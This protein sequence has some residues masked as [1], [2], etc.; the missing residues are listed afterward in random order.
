MSSI[1]SMKAFPFATFNPNKLGFKKSKELE[2]IIPNKLGGYSS[3]TVIGLNSNGFHGLLVSGCKGLRR[4]VYLQKL[5]DEIEFKNSVLGL[6]TNEYSDGTTSD[7]YRY[8][9]KFEFS[10]DSVSFYYR[11]KGVRVT[12]R[13]T[14]LADKNALIALYSVDN[15]S[16]DKIRFKVN[17]LVNSRGFE[18]LTKNKG[19]EFKPRFF[20]KNIIGVNSPNGYITFQSDGAVCFETSSEQRWQNLF[21]SKDETEE[22]SY[23]PAYFTVDVEPDS[24][25]EFTITAI[26]YYTEEETAQAFK[27]LLQGY[28][29]KG[30]ILS[31]GKGTSIFF[32]LNVADTFIVDTDSKKT[33]VS[34]YPHLGDRGRDAMIALPG[35]TLINGRYKD[36][37]QIFEHF[38]NYATHKGIPSRFLAGKPEYGDIDTSLWLVDRLYQYI[39][40]VGVEEGKNFLHT[41]WWVLK[42]IMGNYSEMEKD[43]ILSHHGGTWMEALERNNAVEV[44]GLWYNA[45]RIM[46]KFAKLMDDTDAD[47][48]R[49]TY[50]RFEENFLRKFWNGKYLSD[51]PEDN[52]LRPNQI[53][54]LSLDFNV[55]DD[56]LSRKVLS[57]VE[58]ELLTPFGLRSLSPEDPNYIGKNSPYNGG[59]WPW[60]LGPYVKTHIKLHGKRL[61]AQELLEKI[62][63]NHIKEGGLGTISEV[64]EGDPPFE[65]RGCISY[66]CSVAELLRCYFEDIMKRRPRIAEELK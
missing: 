15:E 2:W 62:F 58:K 64:L 23:C 29:R 66:A 44:Q 20:T 49:P 55:L 59:V 46:E 35:L 4:M 22:Y 24:T 28:A 16:D 1:G 13:I 9:N 65:S 12:K 3:S 17:L 57:A 18:R 6:Y 27:E 25:E 19:I 32:L 39:K 43:G 38:L 40:Y 11:A 37:E 48:F 45:L 10:Y 50:L 60:L 47:I 7:G 42:D 26:G 34:G 30:R 33:I 54:L 21:Y 41:Y 61:K 8:L 14:P 52:S 56:S 31:S 36:A 5:D 53:I 63:E 51:S